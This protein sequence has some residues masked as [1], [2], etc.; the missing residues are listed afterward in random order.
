MAI[1][2]KRQ[3]GLIG[4]ILMMSANVAMAEITPQMAANPKDPYE[5]FN[6]V[7]FNFNDSLDRNI[8]KPVAEL[9]NKI[10]PKPLGR[11]ISNMFANIDTIPVIAN[12]LL[13]ANFYQ[14]TSDAWRLGLNST[15]GLLGFFD[16]ASKMGLEPNKEDFGL[17]LAR[18]GFQDSNYLVLPFFGPSTVRDAIAMP[19]NYQLFTIYP[20]IEPTQTRRAV[21]GLAVVVARADLL[22]FQN[23]FEQASF[24][25]YA[26]MRNAYLQ[27]RQY[28]I[29]RNKELGD[30]YLNNNEQDSYPN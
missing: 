23:V 12:D 21:Y 20:Y 19:I 11:G 6:R 1:F 15:I 3:I 16:V 8:L 5:R 29:E 7:M 10:M 13:Q 2:R 30:P 28:M 9:Y 27:R 4:L 22:R 17:T 18:W 14:A 24:D 26:F 25:K